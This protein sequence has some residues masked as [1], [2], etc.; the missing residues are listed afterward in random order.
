MFG[1]G[2]AKKAA[3]D[4]RDK[5]EPVVRKA[6]AETKEKVVHAT[7]T[8]RDKVEPVVRKAAA[9]TQE[10]VA[11]ATETVHDLVEPTVKK[12]AE[13][14][15]PGVDKVADHLPP[16]LADRLHSSSTPRRGADDAEA[17]ETSNEA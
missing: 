3:T 8:A 15:Q 2:R 1:E 4:A 13:A 16:K 17:D 6:A 10:K 14:M 12:V 7:E 5:V 11:H 9:E